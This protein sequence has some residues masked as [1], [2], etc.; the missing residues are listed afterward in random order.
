MLKSGNQLALITGGT[1]GIGRAL[2]DV[3]AERGFNLLLVSNQADALPECKQQIEDRFPA[4]SCMVYYA[5]LSNQ[6]SAAE[7]YR[8]CTDNNL[9]VDVLVNNAGILLFS[10]VA[11]AGPE[12]IQT[13][14]NLHMHTPVLLCRYFGAEMKER[15]SGYILNV[16]SIS[17]VMPFPGISLYGPT[18]T[19][20]RYFSR[21]LRAEMRIYGV[22][23]CCLIP[24]AT[25][26]GL[27]DP[28][29]VN[30]SLARKLGVMQSSEYVAKKALRALLYKRAECI[31]GI[32]NKLTVFAVPLIPPALIYL[33]HKH[34]NLLQ[35]GN[36]SLA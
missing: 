27:Y 17:S 24:G 10:E 35:K 18:K 15:K 2:A 16:S 8:H 11:G 32:L 28:A 13:I 7:L 23:V 22:Q 20:M 6:H 1:S 33:L 19:F 36:Q 5:D 9:Q 30:L 26:T 34:T 29:K 14:L 12:R 3:F 21:A 31:P 25:Q 4:I